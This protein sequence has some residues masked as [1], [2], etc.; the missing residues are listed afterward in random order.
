MELDSLHYSFTSIDGYKKPFNF[1][2]SPRDAGKTTIFLV[3]KAYRAFS[4]YKRP[5][6]IFVRYQAEITDALIDS[7][8]EIINK[9]IDEPIHLHYKMGSKKDGTVDIRVDGLKGGIIFRLIALNEPLK[10]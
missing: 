2:M 3:T 1:I 5:T 8:E 4:L 9:F 10:R 6:I 7:Y